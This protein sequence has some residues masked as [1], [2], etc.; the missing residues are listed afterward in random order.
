M[1]RNMR[2][3]HVLSGEIMLIAAVFLFCRTRLNKDRCTGCAACE[4]NC[5]TGTLESREEG[6]IRVFSYALFQCIRC[7][8]C[9]SS[10]PEQ[11]AELRHEFGL[12]AFYRP[13]R[14]EV[15]QSVELATCQGCG[16]LFAPVALL[17]KVG[18]TISDDYRSFCSNCKKKKLASDFHELAP[19]PENH[20]KRLTGT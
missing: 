1:E 11:A 8:A 20:Q 10:C 5:P 16:A 2:L 18:Q 13:F 9:V 19:W 6:K 4:T 17:D 7:G 15:V 3:L 14:S 12:K